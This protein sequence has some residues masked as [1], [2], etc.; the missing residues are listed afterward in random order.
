MT[1]ADPALKTRRLLTRIER[2]TLRDIQYFIDASN[3]SA[4]PEISGEPYSA[5][6]R[7]V[8]NARDLVERLHIETRTS[9]ANIRKG[10][11]PLL[12][13]LAEVGALIPFS[14]ARPHLFYIDADAFHAQ[15]PDGFR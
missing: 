2:K 11:Q 5:R 13:R 1:T 15:Y 6:P 10:T 4:S 14:E 9:K 8:L 7:G 12:A 3:A